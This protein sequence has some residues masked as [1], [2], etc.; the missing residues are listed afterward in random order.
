MQRPLSH[1]KQGLSCTLQKSSFC[2]PGL[3][4]ADCPQQHDRPLL[5]VLMSHD[6]YRMQV[7]ILMCFCRTMVLCIY[8]TRAVCP[9]AICLQENPALSEYFQKFWWP[10]QAGRCR[11]VSHMALPF[12]YLYFPSCAY[13]SFHGL[14]GLGQ[15]ITFEF[16]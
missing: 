12:L 7:P 16:T 14:G 2:V 9:A 4:Q 15:S 8:C 10:C 13:W 11:Q 6:H 3:L 1:Y 5:V